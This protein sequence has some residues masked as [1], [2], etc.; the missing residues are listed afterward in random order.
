MQRNLDQTITGTANLMLYP[1]VAET[2]N[3]SVSDVLP[4]MWRVVATIGGTTPSFTFSL[5]ASVIL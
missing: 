1:G 5:G 4:K 2:A 3:V